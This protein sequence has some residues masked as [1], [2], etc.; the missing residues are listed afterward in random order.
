MH[1]DMRPMR[2]GEHVIVV[3]AECGEL[4]G[5]NKVCKFAVPEFELPDG[6]RIIQLEDSGG[7]I[8]PQTIVSAVKGSGGQSVAAV[9]EQSYYSTYIGTGT[10][11]RAT[12]ARRALRS[13]PRS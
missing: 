11:G 4:L 12:P 6:G 2:S 10:S 3:T 9:L 1:V 5:V 7:P 8:F 13:T